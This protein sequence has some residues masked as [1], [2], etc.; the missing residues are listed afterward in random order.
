[1]HVACTH[2]MENSS[3]YMKHR[4]YSPE[5]THF[6]VSE[7]CLMPE[8]ERDISK[9]GNWQIQNKEIL[10]YTCWL[11]T[12]CFFIEIFL[13]TRFSE[14]IMKLVRDCFQ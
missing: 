5:L 1:M 9:W 8:R 11:Y 2:R 7:L 13:K 10:I 6:K 3:S 14:N 12:V 4:V